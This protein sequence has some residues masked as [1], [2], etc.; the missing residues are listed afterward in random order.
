M[1]PDFLHKIRTLGRFYDISDMSEAPSNTALYGAWDAER[2]RLRNQLYAISKEQRLLL[3]KERKR[4]SLILKGENGIYEIDADTCKSPAYK[5]LLAQEKVLM[6]ELEH[7]FRREIEC[8]LSTRHRSQEAYHIYLRI[9]QHEGDAVRGRAFAFTLVENYSNREN[10]LHDLQKAGYT[11]YWTIGCKRIPMKSGDGE[12]AGNRNLRECK[13]KKRKSKKRKPAVGKKRSF[14]GRKPRGEGKKKNLEEQKPAYW[15]MPHL[16]GLAIATHRVK[17]DRLSVLK[18]VLGEKTFVR[19]I[20]PPNPKKTIVLDDGKLRKTGGRAAALA[21]GFLAYAIYMAKNYDQP[22]SIKHLNRS[23]GGRNT[24]KLTKL[25]KS[26]LHPNKTRGEL[27]AWARA[28]EAKRRE[29]GAPKS[30]KQWWI[31]QHW[32]EI[33]AATKCPKYNYPATVL[34]RDGYVYTIKPQWENEFMT[35]GVRSVA[36]PF[37][38]DLSWQ[39]KEAVRIRLGRPPRSKPVYKSQGGECELDVLLHMSRF[40]RVIQVDESPECPIYSYYSVSGQVRPHLDRLL[41]QKAS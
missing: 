2:N 25:E 40:R 39:E 34:L 27:E 1:Y 26:R 4:Q 5:R 8:P 6:D 9:A 7:Q 35:V 17:G 14:W 18:E 38:R 15:E 24:Q 13:S 20:T 23:G 3:Y 31:F 36:C 22:C 41:E 10:L 21:Q 28:K 37:E 16:H 29:I 30:G 33:S 32:E 11:I 19:A 12:S